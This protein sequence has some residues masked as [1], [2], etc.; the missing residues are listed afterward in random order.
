MWQGFTVRGWR[1]ARRRQAAGGA[2]VPLVIVSHPSP[3][4][5]SCT[6]SSVQ[7]HAAARCAVQWPLGGR[8]RDGGY[9]PGGGRFEARFM[10]ARPT[11]LV[12][13]LSEHAT[14]PYRATAGAAGYDLCSAH[15][16]VVPARGK[17]LL[18]T[19][20]AIAVPSGTYGRVGMSGMPLRSDARSP[21]AHPRDCAQLRGRDWLGR[22]PSM[23]GLA[24]LVRLARLPC[25]WHCD[26][27]RGAA[28]SPQT[29]TTGVMSASSYSTTRMPILLV[30]GPPPRQE[31]CHTST[32]GAPVSSPT[33][34]PLPRSKKG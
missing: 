29:R 1:R 8:R 16:G 25:R 3:P 31:R 20:L 34:T 6:A 10:M 24:S 17:A 13:K 18:K 23:L 32:H 19:D 5:R 21:C 4:S 12:K 28:T 22:T 33:T 2:P 30:R 26:N 7:C 14:L 27:C 15:D 11:L 9:E